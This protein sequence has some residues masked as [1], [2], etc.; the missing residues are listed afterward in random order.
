[1]SELD[2]LIKNCQNKLN[3]KSL[4]LSNNSIDYYGKNNFYNVQVILDLKKAGVTS[5]NISGNTFSSSPDLKNIDGIT[6]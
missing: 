3:F 1:M 6:T 4:N 2:K 5:I